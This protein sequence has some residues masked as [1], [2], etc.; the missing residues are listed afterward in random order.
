MMESDKLISPRLE[1]LRQA[2][3]G[4]QAGALDLFWEEIEE[5]GE[6]LF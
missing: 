1:M 3:E 6:P 5:Q 2:L 4:G